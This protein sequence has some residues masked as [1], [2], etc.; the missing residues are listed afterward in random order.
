MVLKGKVILVV[1][2]GVIA[3]GAVDVLARAGAKIA[4]GDI[5]AEEAE[6]I[7]AACRSHGVESIAMF[8][9]LG[10]PAS[11]QSTAISVQKHFGQI[12]GLY[13]NGSDAAAA[14]LD[15]DLLT[16]EP[17]I[18]ERALRINLTG[19]F[20]AIRAVLPIM[21]EA[22]KGS[23]VCTSSDDAFQGAPTR[24]GYATSKAAI[25]AMMRHV[26]SRWGR[27]G[28]RCNAICP[29]LIPHPELKGYSQ[30]Q[31]DAFNQGFLDRTPSTRLGR[32]QDIGAMVRLLLS[33]DG[34]WINGQ[35]ISV[36][37]GFVMR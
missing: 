21:L 5:R 37:G 16:V 10:D 9:D 7:A 25:L 8:T 36:D 28:I 30:E 12:D 20:H 11:L 35:T 27:D 17:E 4:I 14:L 33:D 19:G 23:I 24:V 32:P 31:V 2:G 6:T 18:W 15:S 22:G 26:A 13:L 34:E 29:G 1:G 3:R